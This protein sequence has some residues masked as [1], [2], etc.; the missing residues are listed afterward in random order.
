MVL[1]L[2]LLVSFGRLFVGC[3][4]SPPTLSER[5]EGGPMSGSM[6][7]HPYPG[8]SCSQAGQKGDCGT[9]IVKSETF[10]QC[11]IGTTTCNGT[12]W[13]PCDGSVVVSDKSFTGPG[14]RLVSSQTLTGTACGAIDMCDPYCE[15]A[16]GE[17]GLTIALSEGGPPPSSTTV[18]GYVYDPGVNVPLPNIEVY[19][20]TG[21]LVPLP[22]GVNCDT[23]ATLTSPSSSA[24]STDVNGHFKLPVT[25]TAGSANI[26]MQTGRWRRQI[27]V[28]GITSGVDNPQ[29]TCTSAT[30][31]ACQT[32]LPQTAAE[33][34]IPLIAIS[35]GSL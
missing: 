16:A 12:T 21:A 10:T 14:V 17:G 27:T 18:S 8:C 3:G 19:Q 22:D 32:R 20:P 7:G 28:S 9:V 29:P 2:A 11:S 33:G 31:A 24:T 15:V 35:M 23:C 6:C 4:Q 30:A 25:P 13:G 34:N 26:V 1:T 5:A